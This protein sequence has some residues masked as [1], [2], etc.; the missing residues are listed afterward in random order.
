MPH[1]LRCKTL[2][3][4]SLKHCLETLLQWIWL[5][6]SLFN[7]YMLLFF[8]CILSFIITVHLYSSLWRTLMLLWW[9]GNVC[10]VKEDAGFLLW[11]WLLSVLCRVR[12]AELGLTDMWLSSC[13]S[14]TMVRIHLTWSQ[15]GFIWSCALQRD[16]EW[17]LHW[18]LRY[19]YK[20]VKPELCWHL[21]LMLLGFPQQHENSLIL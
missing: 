18:A 15:M 21:L 20:G 8:N 4:E 14:E 9:N 11:V 3:A 6:K 17:T 2:N 1:R 16:S 10:F 19:L 12:S 5:A 7:L 13:C